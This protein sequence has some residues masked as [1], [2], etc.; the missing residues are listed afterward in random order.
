[1]FIDK[2]RIYVLAGRG[3]NGSISFRREKFVPR[4]GPDGGD[5]GKGGDIYVQA[6]IK[7]NTLLD[8]RYRHHFKAEHGRH[9]EGSNRAGKSGKDLWIAVPRGTLVLDADTRELLS[10]LNENEAFVLVARGGRGGRGN[11]HFATATKQAPDFAQPGEPGQE[12][13]LELELKLIA[14]VGLIGL[15]NAGKST[16]LSRISSAKP[17]IADY[18]FTTLEPLLG[19][20]TV[21]DDS[22]IVV[23]DIPGM[24]EGAAKGHGLGLEF[25]RHVERTKVLLHLIDVS[26]LPEQGPVASFK[27]IQKELVQYEKGLTDKPQI[28]VATKLDVANPERLKDLKE[29]VTAGNLPFAAISAATGE[30]LQDLLFTVVRVLT[31]SE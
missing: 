24:I 15:P 12:R 29:F 25:L 6:T 2:A 13:Y 10:D 11:A 14:D 8:F 16:L 17:K 27:I 4:G 3:G 9:G 7:K 30:G 21:G 5:G 18:P 28:V 22:T 23:A 20:V 19:V 1:M 31:K 26:D